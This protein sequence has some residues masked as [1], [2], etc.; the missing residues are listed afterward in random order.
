MTAPSGVIPTDAISSTGL[1]DFANTTQSE[2]TAQIHGEVES[3]WATLLSGLFDGLTTGV[4]FVAALI[5]K[6]LES[7]FDGV[8]FVV[9]TVSD[10]WSQLTSAFGAKWY[11]IQSAQQAADYAN[12]QLAASSAD[13]FD[14]FDGAAG[15]LDSA[16]W[17]TTGF[18]GGAGNIAID[19]A[20]NAHWDDS[21]GATYGELARWKAST[22][23]SDYQ[24]IT[25]V[26]ATPPQDPFLG[27][28]SFTYLLGRVKNSGSITDGCVFAKIGNNSIDIGYF[29]AGTEYSL[30]STSMTKANGDIWKFDVG[31]TTSVDDFVLYRNGVVA[32]SYNSSSPNKGASYRS[33]GFGMEAGNRNV[34]LAQTSPGLIAV[35]S[36][37]EP[38]WGS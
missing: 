7:V 32:L 8:S 27:S 31:S 24:S 16:K 3:P 23:V 38:W 10:A 30:T 5:K 26:M 11:D 17:D 28:D 9:N 18:G 13:M 4:S 15:D 14:L 21:G 25:L 19:G 33:A 35:W 37:T 22:T 12:A 2:W 29:N 1:S 36:Q 34:F 20:G 6:I